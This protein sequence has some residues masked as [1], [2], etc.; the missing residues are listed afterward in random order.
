MFPALMCQHCLLRLYG[1]MTSTVKNPSLV[2]F[3]HPTSTT[4]RIYLTLLCSNNM[5][6]KFSVFHSR[7]L[8]F[9]FWISRRIFLGNTQSLVRISNSHRHLWKQIW[10][11]LVYHH[12]VASST[13]SVFGIPCIASIIH[14]QVW[15]ETTRRAPWQHSYCLDAGAY[16]T[17]TLLGSKHIC[18]THFLQCSPILCQKIL[19]P[20]SRIKGWS[21]PSSQ[22]SNFSEIH[23]LIPVSRSVF[24]R[25]IKVLTSELQKFSRSSVLT[26]KVKSTWSHPRKYQ[27]PSNNGCGRHQIPPATSQSLLPHLITTMIFESARWSKPRRLRCNDT[28]RMKGRSY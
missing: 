12:F 26:L 19:L 22:S 25:L 21:K 27:K 28:S 15:N 20:S 4:N 14:R 13:T 1:R 5:V 10:L 11:V 6:K 7:R 24:T 8:H 16:R 9:P 17:G 3:G 2:W 18:F 23:Y